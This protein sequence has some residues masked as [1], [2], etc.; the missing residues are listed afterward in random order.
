MKPACI[1]IHNL[2]QRSHERSEQIQYFNNQSHV[3]LSSVSPLGFI[4]PLK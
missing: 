2:T 1:R 3:D 4:I